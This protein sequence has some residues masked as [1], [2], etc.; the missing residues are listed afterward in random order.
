MGW[1]IRNAC[2][3]I[4]AQ[5]KKLA[6]GDE[7]SPLYKMKSDDLVFADGKIQSKTNGAQGKYFFIYDSVDRRFGETRGYFRLLP[8]T[9]MIIS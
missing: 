8:S 9:E 2:N 6:I 5:L 4:Q 1:A 7:R 3:D